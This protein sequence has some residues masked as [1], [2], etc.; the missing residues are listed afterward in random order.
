MAEYTYIP[1]QTVEDGASVLFN[2]EPVRGSPA[3]YHRDGSGI[4]TLR[5]NTNQCRARYKNLR[6]QYRRADG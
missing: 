6:R 2:A 3:V 5:G 4:I 1:I